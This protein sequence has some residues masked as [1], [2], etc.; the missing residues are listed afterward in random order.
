[1]S[2]TLLIVALVLQ[3]CTSQRTATTIKDASEKTNGNWIGQYQ[4][5]AR[6]NG[7]GGYES[8]CNEKLNLTCDTKALLHCHRNR[9]TC[10]HHE[11]MI[12]DAI[13]GQCVVK[14]GGKCVYGREELNP[15]LR[16]KTIDCVLNG[17]CNRDN[18]L[19]H[20]SPR[21][22]N[23]LN[24]S[25]VQQKTFDQA[26]HF[27]TECREDYHLRC[28]TGFCQC[29]PNVSTRHRKYE[30]CLGVPG[31]KAIDGNCIEFS[32][33]ISF[34]PL[35]P[36]RCQCNEGY[37]RGADKKCHGSLNQACT[38]DSLCQPSL[39]CVQGTCKCPFHSYQIYDP[40]KE[41][42]LSDAYG[43]CNSSSDCVLTA[44]CNTT[45]LYNQCEC[46]PGYIVGS[47]RRCEKSL[48][49]LRFYNA[50]MVGALVP[51]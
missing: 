14:A 13:K 20:C 19:C 8:Y 42:C 17:Y 49:P 9:C 41:T 26:C 43:P 16:L 30:I 4:Y 18:G 12:F 29:D 3:T 51:N 27:D 31:E 38:V 32:E 21:H 40:S 25:C 6:A 15:D 11:E 44:F 28:V 46:K 45:G 50:G 10:L 39:T 23:S 34:S 2:S 37:T 5:L 1:M 35:I 48:A 24:V 7:G 47:S 22:Y 36:T 33:P